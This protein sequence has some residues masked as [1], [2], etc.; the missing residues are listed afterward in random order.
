MPLKKDLAEFAVLVREG[1]DALRNV[2]NEPELLAWLEG[3]AFERLGPVGGDAFDGAQPTQE[4]KAREWLAKVARKHQ[5]RE[6]ESS[7][8]GPSEA[9]S[10]SSWSS[11]AWVRK[12]LSEQRALSCLLLT[13]D[14]REKIASILDWMR[15]AEGPLVSGD[16]TRISFEQAI[17]A[18]HAWIEAK[19]KAYA[20]RKDDEAAEEGTT[21][22][23]DLSSLG[24]DGMAGAGCASI[25]RWLWTEKER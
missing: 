19:A 3:I 8:V 17:K 1:V 21:L 23:V 2:V 22:F 4:A 12:A 5:L 9:S 13:D 24:G 7:E 14:E 6:G 18:E 20:K 15:S 10:S 25:Q 16:W 11:L